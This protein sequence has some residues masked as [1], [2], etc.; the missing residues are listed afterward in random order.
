M[1]NR[2]L[3]KSLLVFFLVVVAG[4]PP[5]LAQ[6][7]PTFRLLTFTTEGSPRLGATEGN[8]ALD[9]VDIH[10]AV[11]YLMQEQ[12]QELGRLSYIPADMKTLIEAGSDSI[13]QV[14]RVYETI[15]RLET[16]GR[17][18]EPG[19]GERVFYPPASVRYLPPVPNP[20]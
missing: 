9:I 17:F 13:A 2:V 18:S 8:G 6:E 15:K 16:G 7:N 11:R 14:R 5:G 4:S 1:K 19:G 20:S 12:P 10:N 3:I